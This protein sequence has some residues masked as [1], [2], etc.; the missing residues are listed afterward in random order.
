[1]SDQSIMETIR[2]YWRNQGYPLIEVG[3]STYTHT[4]KVS[5]RSFTF[6]AIS[7]NLGP[8]GCPPLG[9]RLPTPPR[10]S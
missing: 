5:G 8:T 2:S 4:D 6:R 1:M 3:E 7:S 10:R 9:E